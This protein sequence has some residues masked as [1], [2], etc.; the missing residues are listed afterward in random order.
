MSADLEWELQALKEA[1]EAENAQTQLAWEAA[2]ALAA[3]VPVGFGNVVNELGS[4]RP[5]LRMEAARA[6]V[7]SQTYSERVAKAVV[8]AQDWT[9]KT[10]VGQLKKKEC[11]PSDFDADLV[12]NLGYNENFEEIV[13][14]D[15]D[16]DADEEDSVKDEFVALGDFD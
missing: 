2:A 15:D 11:L 9:L 6:F 10:M 4:S 13:S 5:V 7:K 3:R 8:E 12:I 16:A 14:D 1:R